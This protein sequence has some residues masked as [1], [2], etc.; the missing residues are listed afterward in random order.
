M[1]FTLRVLGAIILLLS[2][3]VCGRA[4]EKY[5]S[6]SLLE[7]EELTRALRHIKSR[8]STFLS[9]RREL[10][11][12]FE[13]E[14]LSRSG[15]LLRVA[16]GEELCSALEKSSLSISKA[17]RAALGAFFSELGRGYRKEELSRA[18]GA[19]SECEAIL[20]RERAE[21]PKDVKIVKTLL[22]AGALAL[23]ILML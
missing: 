4:Y 3:I 16:D 1:S 6:R 9:P 18:D 15:F 8:I 23:V 10:L 7:L 13:S 19:I 14:I 22:L 2:A 20:S 11:S 5:A 17:A 21:L 12:G